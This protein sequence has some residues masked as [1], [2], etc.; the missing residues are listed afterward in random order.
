VGVGS[1]LLLGQ[2]V[3][4]LLFG[5]TAFDAPTLIVVPL[6]LGAMT[7]VASWLPAR[8]A[9]NVDPLTAIRAD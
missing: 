6:V 8:R 1:A 4:S 3:K 9:M 5:V 7:I 2:F